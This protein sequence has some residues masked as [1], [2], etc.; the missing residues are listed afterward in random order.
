MN[1]PSTI[2]IGTS[3]WLQEPF[4]GFLHSSKSVVVTMTSV[5]L[6]ME[7]S[8][9]LWNFFVGEIEKTWWQN[10]SLINGVFLSIKSL[11][12][13]G[14]WCPLNTGLER[15]QFGLQTNKLWVFFIADFCW[16]MKLDVSRRYWDCYQGGSRFWASIERYWGS[17]EIAIE[18]YWDCYQGTCWKCAEDALFL[19]K[20]N[21]HLQL[22]ICL[23]WTYFCW[24]LKLKIL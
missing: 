2:T 22:R 3:N 7:F 21:L 11:L 8:D 12:I 18:R 4:E 14:L 13:D 9:L 15:S 17:I 19:S 10:L 23:D 5:S 1:A 16:S 20:L 24:N 6:P